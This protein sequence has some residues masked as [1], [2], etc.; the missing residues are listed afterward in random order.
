M[1]TKPEI[2]FLGG[3]GTVTGSKTIVDYNSSRIMIDSGLFQGIKRLRRKNWEDLPMKA[4]SIDHVLLTHGHLDHVGYLPRLVREG[5]DGTIHATAPT[6]EVT[7]I[8]LRDSAK[9]QEEDAKRANENGHTSHEPA[10]PLYTSRHAEKTFEYFQQEEAG[11]DVTITNDIVANFRPNGHILGSTSISLYVDNKHLVFS[12]DLGRPESLLHY[13]PQVPDNCHALVIESTYGDR[14]HM[15]DDPKDR[16]ESVVHDTIEKGGNLIVPSFTLDRAQ[17]LLYLLAQLKE[18]NKIPD[19]STYL[20][21]PMGVDITKLYVQYSDWHKLSKEDCEKM[22]RGVELIQDFQRT[23]TVLKE[24]GTKIIIAGSGMLAGGRVLFYL[25]HLLED[26]A[27]TILMTGFQ[28]E[29]TRGRLLQ[30]GAHE[31]KFHGN[32]YS[33]K[34]DVRELTNLSAHADQGEIIEW[35]RDFSGDPKKVFI[36]HGKPQASQALRV[37]LSDV[38]D[39]NVTTVEPR[40]S[41]ALNND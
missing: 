4:S 39:W 35:L 15:D 33:V 2:T 20:D 24:S 5:F 13:P 30:R 29:G 31:L 40:Q 18:E 25:K 7:K 11:E 41:Y 37:K 14:L 36:N 28:A 23:K 21:S 6:L 22:C 26:P 12:G 8:I 32:Y 10:K 3:A 38:F 34:A 9:I 27:T 19:C 16:L 17:E 1:D